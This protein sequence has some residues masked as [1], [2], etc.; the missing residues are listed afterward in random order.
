MASEQQA[1]NRGREAYANSK[2]LFSSIKSSIHSYAADTYLAIELGDIA[3]D[4]FEGARNEVD[5]FVRSHCPKAAEKLIAINERMADGTSESR[6]AALTSCRR[7]LMDVADLLFPSR[8]ADWTDAKGKSRQ[9]GPEQY[10]N[11]LLAYIT[12]AIQKSGSREVIELEL[13]H[14]ADRLDAIYEK[15]CKAVSRGRLRTGGATSCDPHL[16][17]RRGNG[18][19]LHSKVAISIRALQKVEVSQCP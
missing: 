5:A 17:I 1:K 9:V 16:F 4:I 19:A 18:A 14:L 6:T 12:E 13:E 10:K 11:R 2:A 7:L 8:E 3:E 15:A